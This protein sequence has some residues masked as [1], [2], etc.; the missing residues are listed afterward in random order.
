MP[1]FATILPET[2]EE[3]D[4]V[5]TDVDHLSIDELRRSREAWWTAE[6]DDFLWSAFSHLGPTRILD[7]GCG[8]GTFE[9]HL[10]RRLAP[11][12]A[13]VGIDIDARRV[14]AAARDKPQIPAGPVV[15]Y[16][17]GDGVRLP[18]RDCAFGA[19]VV[20]LTL[21]HVSEPLRLLS[22]MRRVTASGGMVIA[23][24]ADNTAQ[25]LQVPQASAGLDAAV[26]AYWCRIQASCQPADIAIGPR[27]PHL[28]DQIGLTSPT[29][30]GYLL[31]HTKWEEPAAFVEGARARFGEIARRH[32]V[33][34]S[35]ECS[36]LIE[37]IEGLAASSPPR[38]CTIATVPLFLASARVGAS[39]RA[40]RMS[41]Q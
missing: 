23:V 32:G 9:Q 7:V 19:S 12:A 41:A 26:A 28:F 11:D 16:A 15:T 24:E 13:I 18:F 35:S 14:A 21:Q 40:D 34:R 1:G 29:V 22:E 31:A 20:I 25:R 5:P 27:L 38:F 4:T 6:F 8:T 33:E 2:G 10:A 37:I 30:R 3:A 39:G 17:V 36:A